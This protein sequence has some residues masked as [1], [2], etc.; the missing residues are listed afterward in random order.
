MPRYNFLCNKCSSKLEEDWSINQYNSYRQTGMNCPTCEEGILKRV[1][2][3]TNSNIE[4]SSDDIKA[5]MKE[6]VMAHVERVKSG[7]I[8]AISDIYG[9]ELNK[10]KVK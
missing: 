4:K 10:L 9:Q 3:C 2:S 7:N 5:D 1:F 8:T 6:E